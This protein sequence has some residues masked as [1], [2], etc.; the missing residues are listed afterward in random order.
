MASTSSCGS[1]GRGSSAAMTSASG[2]VW[3]VGG[4]PSVSICAQRV[5]V[6]EDLRELLL[7]PRNV[8]L[9]EADAGQLGNVE[10]FFAGERHDN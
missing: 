3:V 2:R 10:D 6:V 9:G 7:E 5:E 1:D 4:T 8:L